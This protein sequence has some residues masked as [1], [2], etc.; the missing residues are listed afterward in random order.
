MSKQL[1]SSATILLVEDDEEIRDDMKHFLE[2]Q[3]YHVAL[4]FDENDSLRLISNSNLEIRLILI[5]QRMLS[6][7]ALAVGRRIREHESVADSAPVVVIPFEFTKDLEGT[8]QS[9]GNGDY[10]SYIAN[11]QQLEELLFQLLPTK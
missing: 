1:R 11:G 8:N 4:A 2:N 7:E 3:G 6:D 9:I 5:N 10:K